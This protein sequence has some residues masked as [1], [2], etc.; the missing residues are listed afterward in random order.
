MIPEDLG[1]C[2]E[3]ATHRRHACPFYVLACPAC[4]CLTI[5]I[6]G[7]GSGEGRTKCVWLVGESKGPCVVLLVRVACPGLACLST[8]AFSSSSLI[9]PHDPSHNSHRRSDRFLGPIHKIG[10]TSVCQIQGL[11]VCLA[12]LGAW[13]C[14]RGQAPTTSP[15]PQPSSSTTTR[16]R[17]PCPT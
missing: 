16:A 3:R 17:P 10:K 7:G 9:T 4:Q 14:V 11:C 8:H 1:C 15:S 12:R 13:S 6:K 2:S 5:G